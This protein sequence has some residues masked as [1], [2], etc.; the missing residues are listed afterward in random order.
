M[1]EKSPAPGWWPDITEPFRHLGARIADWFAPR[2]EASAD[3]AAYRVSVELPGVAEAD[4]EVS[5]RDGV[6][7]VKGEKRAERREEG[8]GYFFSEREY[9]R[10]QRSFRLPADADPAKIE[11]EAAKGVLTVT[12]GRRGKAEDAGKSI[13]IRAL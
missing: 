2:S 8:E 10:F 1:V 7:T 5:V 4:M 6:L 3:K 9:G 13:P 11:A 12:I